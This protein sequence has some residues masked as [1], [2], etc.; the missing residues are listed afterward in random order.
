MSTESIRHKRHI[1]LTDIIRKLAVG[2]V[3]LALAINLSA[4]GSGGDGGSPGGEN[5][6]SDD[7]PQTVQITAA[8]SRTGGVA[9][10]G[11]FFNADVDS[12][13]QA[14]HL[15]EY[16]WDFGDP[17]GG[18]WADSGASKN[19]DKGPVA[20]HVFETAGD[21]T[22]TLTVRDSTGIVG[23]RTFLIIVDDPDDEY[24][25]SGTV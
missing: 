8:A 18:T 12:L 3:L 23:T 4:C 21:Y 24:T 14:F 10:L 1:V 22:V 20:A 9:P 25:G 16:T 19:T 17:A 13:T 6:D 11:V 5:D 7:D 2:I 15:L